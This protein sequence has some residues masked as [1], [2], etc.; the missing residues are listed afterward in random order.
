MQT[1]KRVVIHDLP[2]EISAK[3][4]SSIDHDFIII[5]ANKKAAKCI[6]CFKC[7]LQ[8]PGY[9]GFCDHL[10]DIGQIV[11]SSRQLIIITQMVY[12]GLSVPVKRVI[13]RSIPGITPFFKKRHGKLHH[14]QRYPTETAIRAIFYHTEQCTEEEKIQS[15]RYIQHMGINYYSRH[16]EI[17]HVE[18]MVKHVDLSEENL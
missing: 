10:N 1:R 15:E 6:G 7:W 18:G 3:L 14:L 12:G 5:N 8:T 2:D 13:D 11:L 16:N 9:C 17:I 4:F